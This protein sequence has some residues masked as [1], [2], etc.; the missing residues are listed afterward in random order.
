MVVWNES[1]L[2]YIYYLYFV[3]MYDYDVFRNETQNCMVKLFYD[4]QLIETE[5]A[6]NR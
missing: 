6:L 2:K 1:T 4:Y 5:Q 3:K